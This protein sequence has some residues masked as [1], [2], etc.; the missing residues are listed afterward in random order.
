MYHELPRIATRSFESSPWIKSL[1][2][3]GMVLHQIELDR[4]TKEAL[5]E[6]RKLINAFH[7]YLDNY[8]IPPHKLTGRIKFALSMS[9]ATC[10]YADAISILCSQR[11]SK[12][13]EPLVRSM[14]EGK[15]SLIYIL[16]RVDDSRL[17]AAIVSDLRNKKAML[18]NI[19][20]YMDK[21]GV[22]KLGEFK[23]ATFESL[24]EEREK[25]IANIEHELRNGN[26]PEFKNKTKF[27]KLHERA[28]QIGI[29]RSTKPES[30]TYLSY[31]TIYSIM[32]G[33]VHLGLDGLSD[34]FSE[35]DK[36]LD[37]NVAETF[38][39]TH[40]TIILTICLFTD[41]A[42]HVLKELDLDYQQL[43]DWV[44]MSLEKIST[45]TPAQKI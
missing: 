45:Y 21:L 37:L 7:K 17:N 12:S 44:Q 13:C 1:Y 25:D 42:S 15:I 30:S 31:L 39:N 11:K 2:N 32:S 26:N 8:K 16:D 35:S 43:L 36:T 33:S 14:L 5:T 22:D 3:E 40:R 23:R 34:W 20:D 29:D 27:P 28:I 18:T 9:A 6:L 24:V 19:L 4:S 38:E 10:E 41:I